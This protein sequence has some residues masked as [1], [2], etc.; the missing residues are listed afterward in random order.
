M[1][2]SDQQEDALHNLE[3]FHRL[4]DGSTKKRLILAIFNLPLPTLT[5]CLLSMG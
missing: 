5:T 4:A 2:C 1:I 3:S